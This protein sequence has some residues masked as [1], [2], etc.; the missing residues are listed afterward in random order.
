MNDGR[1]SKQVDYLNNE[2][3]KDNEEPD[4]MSILI[5]VD[6]VWHEIME[7]NGIREDLF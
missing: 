3:G 4:V 6:D 2:I 5:G 1:S 7:R